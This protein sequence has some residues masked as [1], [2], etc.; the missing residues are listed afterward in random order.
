[1]NKS[2]IYTGLYNAIKRSYFK[3][4]LFGDRSKEKLKPLH[5]WVGNTIKSF[6]PAQ[7]SVY[8]LNGKEVQT[9]GEYYTKIID[10]AIVKENV[11]IIP[12]RIGFATVF[13][14]EKIEMAV[15]IKFI[16]SNF[17]QNAN[18]YF[19]NL[20]G[21][22]ANLK[23]HGIKFGHFIVFRDKIPYFERN[24][25][26]KH[27]EILEDHDI[28]KYI[29]L[30][31]ER[32]KFIHV[33]DVIGLEIINIYPIIEEVYKRKPPFPKNTI[34]NVGRRKIII[35]NGID[36]TKISEGK[37]KFILDNFNSVCFFENIKNA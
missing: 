29:K 16:T 30:F 32:G 14:I 36:N 1:M 10:V 26:I 18:N 23:A 9:E 20:L 6:I 7:Y 13:Y 31:Q 11:E 37:K 15:S 4:L 22:C 21:E 35:K 28:N 12:Q 24:K 5:A 25:K 34:K 3:Y 2:E 8:F 33:P 17:K 19:E 27:W